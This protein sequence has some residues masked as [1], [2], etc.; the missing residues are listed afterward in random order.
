MLYALGLKDGIT[1][2][3]IAGLLRRARRTR[4]SR[5]VNSLLRKKLLLR[6]QD[7]RAIAARLRAAI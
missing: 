2:D 1:A 5:A 4:S 7:Q 6:K 3:D